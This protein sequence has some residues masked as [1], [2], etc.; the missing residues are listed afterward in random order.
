MH[1]N[2]PVSYFIIAPTPTPDALF[3]T[4]LYHG[5]FLYL[6]HFLMHVLLVVDPLRLHQLSISVQYISN[7]LANSRYFSVKR[8]R[9][10]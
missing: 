3:Y 9:Y 5:P 8:G 10:T 4:F 6:H 2:H 7:Y 1:I